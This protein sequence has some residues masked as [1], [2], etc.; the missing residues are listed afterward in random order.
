MLVVAVAVVT[1]AQ[2]LLALEE[3]AAVELDHQ[4]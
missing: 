2:V 3:L 1:V 4:E